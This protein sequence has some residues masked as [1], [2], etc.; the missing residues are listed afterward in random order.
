MERSAR[1]AA[2]WSD[3]CRRCD[4][5]AAVAAPVAPHA[6]RVAAFCG[7][8][9]NDLRLI[10]VRN[11]ALNGDVWAI[12]VSAGNECPGKVA[13]RSGPRVLGSRGWECRT[14]SGRGM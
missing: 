6:T 12:N 13:W 1:A 10:V 11:C 3:G 9:S 4:W 7:T 2:A 5:P 8:A 14:R